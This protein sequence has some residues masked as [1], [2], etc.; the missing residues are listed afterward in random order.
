MGTPRSSRSRGRAYRL[1]PVPQ[2]SAARSGGCP[3]PSG[4]GRRRSQLWTSSRR[5][6]ERK[7]PS[8]W[9]HR[10]L[11]S[12]ARQLRNNVHEWQPS[13]RHFPAE[14]VRSRVGRANQVQ[15]SRH[16]K[17]WLP[18]ELSREDRCPWEL[19]RRYPDLWALRLV[20]RWPPPLPPAGVLVW[21]VHPPNWALAYQIAFRGMEQN[22]RK[23]D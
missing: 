8:L 17:F 21:K 13:R 20:E 9:T 2:V 19:H 11:A 5:S 6:G 1:T 16:R 12:T 10:I 22:S 15:S 18:R 3:R 7:M 23:G 4:S 14:I